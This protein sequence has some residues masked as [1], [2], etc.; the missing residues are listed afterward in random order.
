MGADPDGL[1]T[2]PG[3]DHGN[4][5]SSSTDGGDDLF[6]GG[7][8]GG[9]TGG[10]GDLESWDAGLTGSG[11]GSGSFPSRTTKP[12][13]ATPGSSSQ[14]TV[15]QPDGKSSGPLGP[16]TSSNSGTQGG[17]RTTSAS[18]ASTR[19]DEQDEPRF[20]VEHG[21]VPL[22]VA[23]PT[24]RIFGN[25]FT[26]SL[27]TRLPRIPSAPVDVTDGSV[28]R[29]GSTRF[30]IRTVALPDESSGLPLMVASGITVALSSASTTGDDL[31]S[32]AAASGTAIPV[33][34]ATP[35]RWDP[36]LSSSGIES[37]PASRRRLV[38]AGVGVMAMF[39]AGYVLPDTTPLFHRVLDRKEGTG[40]VGGKPATA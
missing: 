9:D 28:P 24:T 29:G 31:T 13:S 1:W 33:P 23:G 6:L 22:M 25:G 38:T 30:P 7:G 5:G 14:S 39:T 10:G 26:R 34:V 35:S 21:S 15:S 27:P 18:P 40:K 37:Q 2:D 12:T 16:A 17:P 20:L 19:S 32:A 36:A 8:G 4:D 3:Y 11:G